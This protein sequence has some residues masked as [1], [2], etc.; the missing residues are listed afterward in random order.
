MKRARPRTARKPPSLQSGR[1]YAAI[2]RLVLVRLDAE[3]VHAAASRLLSW[4]TLIPPVRRVLRRAL[5]VRDP[6]LRVEALGLVFPSPLGLAA[7]FDKDGSSYRGLA[8]LGFG[9]LEI[10]TVT[11]L[12]QEGNPRPRVFRIP[13]ERAL[14]N[15]M[16]FP[17]PGADAVAGRLRKR[18]RGL[19][20][21]VNVGRSKIVDESGTIAD[22]ERSVRAVAAVAD[23]VVINVS[24]PNTPGLRALQTA[25]WLR[26]LVLHARA[27]AGE[28]RPPILV[29]IAPD[30]EDAEIDLIA[31]VAS[32]LEL[33][34]IVAVNTTVEAHRPRVPGPGGERS[35]GGRALRP[36]APAAG[37][38]G[39]PAPSRARAAGRLPDLRGRCRLG[40]G[41]AAPDQG[42]GDPRPG[43]HRLRLRRAAVAAPRQPAVGRARPRERCRLGPGVRRQRPPW[44]S[45]GVSPRRGRWRRRPRGDRLAIRLRP[46]TEPVE[47]AGTVTNPTTERYPR[48]AL[49]SR[50]IVGRGRCQ[51]E[52]TSI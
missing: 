26:Q 9:F 12:P 46:D 32:E 23:F 29:K 27:C 50:K 25:D 39:A 21:G 17:N 8:A 40:R 37:A 3:R 44:L 16:G 20:V 1:V 35:G 15:S 11:A 45:P 31:D 7:G 30:L 49:R 33:D 4:A 34:G 36:A 41:G 2:F 42:R 19:A 10:G 6:A 52:D 51:R 22:Y 18:D 14:V 28:R 47:R 48:R 24:S 38:G 13:G 43:L 5:E